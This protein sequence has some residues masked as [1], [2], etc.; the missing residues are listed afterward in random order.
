MQSG[1]PASPHTWVKAR[2]S[3][4]D[5]GIQPSLKRGIPTAAITPNTTPLCNRHTIIT[6]GPPN[7][8]DVNLDDQFLDNPEDTL[9]WDEIEG[10]PRTDLVYH[11]EVRRL[12]E[13]REE[14]LQLQQELTDFDDYDK[15]SDD[16]LKN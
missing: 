2:F 1:S 14:L 12:L 10:P 9:D 13:I 8:R 11:A 4:A 5:R 6:L 3:C 15:L 16:L 7:M